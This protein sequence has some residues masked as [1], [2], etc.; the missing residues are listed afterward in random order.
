MFT[1]FLKMFTILFKLYNTYIKKILSFDFKKS[2]CATAHPHL[3]V[4]P[5]LLVSTQQRVGSFLVLSCNAQW[6]LCAKVVGTQQRVGSFL[7]LSCNAQW[8]LCAKGATC[9]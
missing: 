7:L 4:A 3:N 9:E 6:R 1:I 5:P 8:R 2:E